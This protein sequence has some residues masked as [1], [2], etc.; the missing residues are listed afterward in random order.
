VKKKKK[1]KKKSNSFSPY[2]S[3]F[4]EQ[5]FTVKLAFCLSLPN[6]TARRTVMWAGCRK[7]LFAA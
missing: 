1:K 5:K 2:S 6:S 7:R 4:G 3:Q